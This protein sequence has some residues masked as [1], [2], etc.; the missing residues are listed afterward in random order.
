MKKIVLFVFAAS[1]MVMVAGCGQKIVNTTNETNT[2]KELP[3][4]DKSEY[5]IDKDSSGYSCL[6]PTEALMERCKEAGGIIKK[7]VTNI[8]VGINSTMGCYVDGK[9]TDSGKK[10]SSN[11]D[12]QG[13][14]EYYGGD[15][16]VGDIS[17]ACSQHKKILFRLPTSVDN[18]YSICS[19]EK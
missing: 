6:K 8:G 13:N 1:C 2:G 19:S 9:T 3:P 7:E 10:C 5:T 15:Y 18:Q 12:C 11:A 4:I 16:V 14:C 17:D